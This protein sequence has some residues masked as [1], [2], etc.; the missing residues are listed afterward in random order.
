MLQKLGKCYPP[1]FELIP[2]F[3]LALN[4]YLTLT[5]YPSLPDRIPTHFNLAGLP[6]SWGGKS[7]ILIQPVV[8]A[9]MYVLLTVINVLLAAVKDPRWLINLPERRKA[10]LT[11]VQVEALRLFLNR[12]LFALKVVMQ[13]LFSYMAYITIEVALGRATG[14]GVPFFIILAI[15]LALAAYMTGKSFRISRPPQ[16]MV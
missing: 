6:D 1:Q 7:S 2:L 12:S 13:A 16:K 8:G 10:A 4:V 14:L 3:L 9:A 11:G 5:Y 15:I